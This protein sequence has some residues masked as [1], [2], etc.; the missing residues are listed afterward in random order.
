MKQWCTQVDYLSALAEHDLQGNPVAAVSDKHRADAK[1]RAKSMASPQ[2]DAEA[3][4][5]SIRRRRGRQRCQPPVGDD[6][7]PLQ[8]GRRPAAV[9]HHP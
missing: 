5:V 9:V 7:Q 1:Q 4:T 2:P 8:L 6:T 3:P